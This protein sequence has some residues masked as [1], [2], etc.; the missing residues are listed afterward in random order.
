MNKSLL[1]IHCSA[2]YC[3]ARK[4]SLPDRGVQLVAGRLAVI[5]L[6]KQWEED[7]HTTDRV[8]AALD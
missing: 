6:C 4:W 3:S 2:Y 5:Q 7:L 1:I 8:Y